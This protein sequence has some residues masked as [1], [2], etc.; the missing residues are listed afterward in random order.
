MPLMEVRQSAVVRS[1]LI[2]RKATRTAWR[3]A[4]LLP[5]PST[6]MD[7]T[8]ATLLRVTGTTRGTIGVWKLILKIVQFRLANVTPGK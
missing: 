4:E 3:N 7:R 5:T 6:N 1:T 2:I 8:T